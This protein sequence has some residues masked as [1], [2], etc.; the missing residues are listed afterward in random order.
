[1]HSDDSLVMLFSNPSSTELDEM[2][3][4]LI[5]LFPVGLRVPNVG[6]LVANPAFAPTT[7]QAMFTASHYHGTVAWSWQHAAYAAGLARQ[8]ARTDVPAP[9]RANLRGAEAAL[10]EGIN[11]TEALRGT[12]FWTFTVR[13]GGYGAVP[14]QGAETVNESNPVQ[15]WSTVWLG[16]ERPRQDDRSEQ[17][18]SRG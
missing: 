14:A 16:I 10:W 11:A 7:V 8:L 13:D 4:R 15:L 18:P 1:M 6:T 5:V 12:E 9:T 17:A 3:Q 2:A